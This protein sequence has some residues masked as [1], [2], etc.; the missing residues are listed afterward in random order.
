MNRKDEMHRHSRQVYCVVCII[1]QLGDSHQELVKSTIYIFN[2][3]REMSTEVDSAKDSSRSI[4]VLVGK[5]YSSLYYLNRDV[6]NKDMDYEAYLSIARNLIE[7]LALLNHVISKESRA[8]ALGRL[9]DRS[10]LDI[11]AIMESDPAQYDNLVL[12]WKEDNGWSTSTV[13]SRVHSL[14][15][16]ELKV[17]YAYMSRVVHGINRDDLLKRESDKYYMSGYILLLLSVEINKIMIRIPKGIYEKELTPLHVEINQII[18]P[19]WIKYG[20]LKVILTLTGFRDESKIYT[21]LESRT[22]SN[23]N[24]RLEEVVTKGYNFYPKIAVE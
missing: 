2:E 3:Y 8:K 4:A 19:A 10:S 1:N 12:R 6:L 15:S 14:G 11:F 7:K 13:E 21:E 18:E 22:I 17:I 24:K 23:Y 20:G 9:Y 16:K 5:I